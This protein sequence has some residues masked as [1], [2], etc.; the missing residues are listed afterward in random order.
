M[1]GGCSSE[2]RL[3]A[4]SRKGAV[5]RSV[6][7]CPLLHCAGHAR[8]G[9]GQAERRD[10]LVSRRGRRA[11][12]TAVRG[13]RRRSPAGSPRRSPRCPRAPRRC[14]REA[15]ASALSSSVAPTSTVVQR[16]VNGMP[17]ASSFSASAFGVAVRGALDPDLEVGI[18]VGGRV[19]LLLGD[20]LAPL[21][22]RSR[23][24]L[25][26]SGLSGSSHCS[27]VGCQ[28]RSSK[29]ACQPCLSTSAWTSC[30]GC[31]R[32]A[33]G[34]PRSRT[35]RRRRG[36]RS[37]GPRSSRHPLAPRACAP[38]AR[39]SA[40]GHVR[41][42]SCMSIRSRQSSFTAGTLLGQLGSAL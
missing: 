23:A 37:P 12:R 41:S 17:S 38:R 18:A 15:S 14:K 40:R 36:S 30:R 26:G 11:T 31:A 42:S 8:A 25:S 35:P 6:A 39:A 16:C 22:R 29:S 2:F 7:R 1:S 24:S 10:P 34:C 20:P 32:P 5:S 3:P 9:A 21:L 28:W 4:S 19:G 13:A 33:R 27:A